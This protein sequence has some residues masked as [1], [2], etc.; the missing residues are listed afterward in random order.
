MS[1]VPNVEMKVIVT[2]GKFKKQ[3]SKAFIDYKEKMHGIGA[4]WIYRLELC[5]AVIKRILQEDL[6]EICITIQSI[7]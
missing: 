1:T 6:F 7:C 5:Q 2:A 4:F 3:K